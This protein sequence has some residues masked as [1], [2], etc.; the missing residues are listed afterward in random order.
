MAVDGG[1]DLFHRLQ[2][3]AAGPRVPPVEDHL[4]PLPRSL[5]VNILEGEAQTIGARGLEIG[6]A[7]AA[8][9]SACS[10]DRLHWFFSHR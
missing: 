6:L 9:W 4:R 8:R 1:G 7:S 10:A 3:A 2:A 5:V